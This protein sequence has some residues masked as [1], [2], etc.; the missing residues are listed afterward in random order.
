M[1]YDR[2]KDPKHVK[3]AKFVKRR[4]KYICQ[5][6]FAENVYLNSHHLNSFDFFINQRFAPSNGVTL[7]GLCHQ[8]FHRMYGFSKN[9]KFQFYEFKKIVSLIRDI[10]EENI[11]KDR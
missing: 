9:T 2:F 6:C 7:C 3:W 8:R 10:S 1:E 4:D 5:V 11:D